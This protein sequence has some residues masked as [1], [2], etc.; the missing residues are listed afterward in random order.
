MIMLIVFVL[1]GGVCIYLGLHSL[2][3]YRGLLHD[4]KISVIF[5]DIFAHEVNAGTSWGRIGVTLILLGLFFLGYVI[6]AVFKLFIVVLF[7]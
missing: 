2:R 6:V 5:W 1:V 3:H 4:N 7:H